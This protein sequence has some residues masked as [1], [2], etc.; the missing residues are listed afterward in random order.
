MF[1]KY[2][3]ISLLMILVTGLIAVFFYLYY[4]KQIAHIQAE[5]TYSI[6]YDQM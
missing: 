6:V 3:L 2:H 4:A 1:K 5:A